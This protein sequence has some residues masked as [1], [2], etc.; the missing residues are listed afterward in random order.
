MDRQPT[1]NALA[2][3]YSEHRLIRA[4]WR[5]PV[6]RTPL[7]IM[8]QAGRY[9]PEYR[10]LRQR[11]KDF[12]V[13]CKTPELACEITLQPVERFDLDAAIIFSDIL[14]VPEAL[15]MKLRFVEGEGPQ[16][17]DPL[18]NSQAIQQLPRIDAASELSYVMEAIRFS[19]EALGGRL[20]LIG[21]AGS[22]WTLATYMIE[23]RSSKD[24]AKIKR[25]LYQDPQSLHALLD[26]LSHTLI[27]YLR[28]Q[29]Q[30][31][32]DVLMIF[33]TWGGVLPYQAYL[34][35]S[36][37]YMEVIVS[38]LKQAMVSAGNQALKKVP[39]ILFSKNTMQHLVAQAATGCDALGLD[40]TA[41]LSLARQRVGHQVAI[42]GNMDPAALYADPLHIQEAVKHVLDDFGPGYGHVFN[43]GHGITPGVDPENVQA[44]IEAV[45]QYGVQN[46]QKEDRQ[47]W[48]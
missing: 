46:P 45:H 29:V 39:I 24:F 40:W 2:V 11:A 30:A 4:L 10:A 47:S 35:F 31:G 18:Q 17:Q 15:G 20:P 22:P 14:V 19:K 13:L 21:F 42:Q 26:H 3:P 7:W 25:W 36:L 1:Q 23:G 37:H 48:P 8:R 27:D 16:F 5:Q 9:L 34:D 44:M 33:D 32:V 41:S 6:D 28:A 12:L 38:A 43:L